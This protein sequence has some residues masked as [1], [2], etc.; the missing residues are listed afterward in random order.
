MTSPKPIICPG[1]YILT[2]PEPTRIRCKAYDAPP[3]PHG[4]SWDGNYICTIDPNTYIGPIEDVIDNRGF[5]TV[6]C[7]TYWIN[8]WKAKRGN[9]EGVSFARVISREISDSWCQRG[10]VHL[11]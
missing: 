5:I 4:V 9:D 1:Q 7:R 11:P 3:P 8:I 2:K 6:L 10:W